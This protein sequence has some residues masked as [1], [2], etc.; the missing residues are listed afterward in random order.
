[1]RQ[2]LIAGHWAL[3]ICGRRAHVLILPSRYRYA[4]ARCLSWDEPDADIDSEDLKI[5]CRV[6]P[7]R[8]VNMATRLFV[9][10]GIVAVS[11]T[12]TI[13]NPT[14]SISCLFRL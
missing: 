12:V 1:M 9:P 4:E 3:P 8:P 10:V 5:D 6:E 11:A 14:N 7:G 13:M 2:A